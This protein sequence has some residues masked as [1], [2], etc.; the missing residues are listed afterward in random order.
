MPPTDVQGGGGRCRECPPAGVHRGGWAAPVVVVSQEHSAGLPVPVESA[1]PPTAAGPHQP[2][3]TAP[4][5][6]DLLQR[7]AGANH[8]LAVEL[9]AIAASRRSLSQCTVDR[10]EQLVARMRPAALIRQ[11]LADLDPADLLGGARE[12]QRLRSGGDAG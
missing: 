4:Q 3:A 11:A 8:A 9:D 5:I 1:P 10:L 7:L 2:P 6:A 12:W